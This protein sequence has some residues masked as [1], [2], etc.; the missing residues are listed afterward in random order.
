MGAIADDIL[1]HYGVG[2]LDGAPGRGSGRYPLGSGENPHQRAKN[3]LERY[4]KLKKEG[5]SEKQIAEAFGILKPNRKG[6]L[7]GYIDGLRAEKQL[8]DYDLT[9]YNIATATKLRESGM[10]LRAIAKEMGY[11]SDSSIRSF[12]AA[13]ATAKNER[14]MNTANILKKSV[15][16]QGMVE[17]GG[18]VN[19]YLNVS[20][21]NFKQALYILENRFGYPVYRGRVEQATNPMNKTT[22]SVLCPPGTEHREIFEKKGEIHPVLPFESSDGGGEFHEKFR[23]PESLDSKRVMIRYADDNSAGFTGDDMDGVVE[24]RRGVED[25]ALKDSAGNDSSYSQVRILVDGTHYIKGMAVYSDD[26]PDGIDVRFNTNKKS[27]TPMMSDP[28]DKN[29]VLKPIKEGMDNPFGALIKENNGQS[30]YMDKDGKMKMRVINKTRDEGD[31]DQWSD[32]VPSQF[33]AKQPKQLQKQQLDLTKANLKAEYES[34]MKISNP[35]LRRE[36]L[37]TFAQ[38]CD[39]NAENLQAAPL[40]GQKY[41]VLL[42]A[43][44]IKEGEIYAPS[45]RDGTKVALIRYPHEGIYQIPVLTVNNSNPK[46]K[47]M[48]PPGSLDAVG[49]RKKAADQLSGADYDGDSV[50]V[51][52][53]SSRVKIAHREP[54]PGLKDYDPKMAYPEREGMR[55]LKKGQAT[56]TQMGMISNLIMDMTLKGAAPEEMERAVRHSMC[57]ID[58]AKHKLDYKRSER[59]NRIPELKKKYQSHIEEDGKEHGGASTLL[60]RAGKEATIPRTQGQPRIDPDTGKLVYKTADDLYY[61]DKKTGKQVMKTQKSTQMKETDDARTLISEYRAPAEIMYA[62][63]ANYQKAMANQARK[64]AIATKDIKYSPNA[65]AIYKTEYDSLVSKVSLAESNRPRERMAQL[66]TSSRIEAIKAE[67][68]DLKKKEISKLRQQELTRAREQVGAHRQPVDITEREFKA[69]QAGAINPTTL[70]KVIK[71]ADQDKLVKMAM[72]RETKGFSNA[73]IVQMKAMQA[74]GYTLAEIA[75]RFGKSPSSISAAIKGTK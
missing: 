24:L 61:T 32:N 62:D 73:Q 25:I 58:A 42:P 57:V 15:D 8:A 30:Y 16:E 9:S 45:L 59:E 17:V 35:T 39:A 10:S 12:L 34:I 13:D 2:A 48:I 5:L 50:Q 22:Y 23:Y 49:I 66:I 27:G 6:V 65:K 28:D 19:Q 67:H 4:T 33:L 52:P 18:G 72:P 37:I 60:T 1:M 68:P 64:E 74:S 31:W 7:E 14:C 26:L 71:Y 69:I 75:K 21:T 55:V 43:P 41:K 70:K 46:M 44:W 54:L 20:T 38:T 47:K 51:I 36:M 63:F 40:R 53:L 3:F 29:Q 56:Q 11:T